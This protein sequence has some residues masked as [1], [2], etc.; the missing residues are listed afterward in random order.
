MK[1]K[2]EMKAEALKRMNLLGLSEEIVSAFDKENQVMVSEQSFVGKDPLFS[3][4]DKLDEDNFKPYGDDP[5]SVCCSGMVFSIIAKLPNEDCAQVIDEMELF[6]KGLVYHVH[7]RQD[8]DMDLCAFFFVEPDA[9]QWKTERE[10]T[11]KEMP[12]AYIVD[13]KDIFSVATLEK[14]FVRKA[15]GRLYRQGFVM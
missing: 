11:E 3:E 15:V 8:D 9:K 5:S 13:F 10:E 6:N 7:R 14:T 12:K 1:N 2:T 4:N